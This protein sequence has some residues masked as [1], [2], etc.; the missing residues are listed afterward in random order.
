MSSY[1][2]EYTGR[3]KS[4]TFDLYARSQRITLSHTN[5]FYFFRRDDIL[6]SDALRYYRS[7]A[8][9]VRLSKN[10]IKA[11]SVAATKSEIKPVVLHETSSVQPTEIVDTVSLVE[12]IDEPVDRKDAEIESESNYIINSPDNFEE[13]V[14][15]HVEA[16]KSDMSDSDLCE[17][18]DMNKTEAEIR[19]LANTLEVDVKRL[20]S[21]DSMITRLVTKKRTELIALLDI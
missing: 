14:E 11:E 12:K 5:K 2:L 18:L 19:E 10:I 3:A 7:L 4:F 13:L 1:K 8:P 21:K 16:N 17:Y 6:T 20:R 15:D 9:E